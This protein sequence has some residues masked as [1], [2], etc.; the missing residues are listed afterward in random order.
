MTNTEI[1]KEIERRGYDFDRALKA[2]DEVRTPEQEEQE[3]KKHDI[4]TLI[5]D[6][7]FGFDCEDEFRTGDMF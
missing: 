4:L 7:C 6:I 2:V 3:I 1:A 5:K